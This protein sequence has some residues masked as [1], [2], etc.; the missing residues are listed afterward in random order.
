MEDKD[1][2]KYCWFLLGPTGI[3]KSFVSLYLG[4]LYKNVII[5]TDA[6]S[7]YKEASIMTAKV[8]KKDQNKVQHKMI[9]ILE[10][11]KSEILSFTDSLTSSENL[12]LRQTISQLRSN[13]E[14]FNLELFNLANSKGYYNPNEKS[15]PEEIEQIRK[16]YI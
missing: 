4:Q 1:Y 16:I 5:N 2:K 3:G 12:E 7:L 6:F 10:N 15:K 13:L 9:D 8:S 14:A 11:T